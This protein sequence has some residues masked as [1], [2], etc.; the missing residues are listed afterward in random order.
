MDFDF[1][2]PPPQIQ[3]LAEAQSLIDALWSYCAEAE[4]CAEKQSL[5]IVDLKEKLNTNSS[6]SSKAPS[7]D[8][9]QKKP[10]KK[11]Y[12]GAGKN[13]RLK[14][15][16][17]PGHSGKGRKLLPPEAVD[18]QVVCLP[19][20]VCKCGGSIQAHP[21]KVKRHQ[22]YE[23]PKIKPIVTEYQQIYGTCT[24]CGMA[25]C[26]SLPKGVAP[27]LLAPRATASVSILSGDYR[28]SKRSVQRLFDDFFNLPISLG[29][30][31]NTER[32]VSDTLKSPVEAAQVYVR[33][34]T[35]G[36]HADETHH[37]QQGN[38]QW[39]WLATTLLV[40]VFIIRGSRS[41]KAAQDLLGETF[42]GILVTD[43]YASYNWI[44]TTCRQF[45][46][47]HL[48]RDLQKISERSG[49]AGRIGDEIL[50]YISRMFRLW[51]L[52]GEPVPS[53]LPD[54]QKFEVDDL[55]A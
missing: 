43:R 10:R 35:E 48:K 25:H 13:R 18:T 4:A 5:Q 50:V 16:G 46:W 29:T 39:M 6:N 32:T 19:E 28:L 8:L 31:S 49:Q 23:L 15:G 45:C 30:V 26:G 7:S 38:K 21:E 47:A 53:L 3:T 17:Q 33:Q 12:H 20:S 54:E 36:V 40:A 41:M 34:H 37:K 55:A 52:K 22:Q 27:T 14:Q 11:K 51:H 1:S 44:K 24:G 2:Q 42:A 9:F